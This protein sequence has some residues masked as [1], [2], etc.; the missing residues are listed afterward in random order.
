VGRA[1]GDP[2]QGQAELPNPLN[3]PPGCAFANRCP[4]AS[5]QCRKTVPVLEQIG[6]E[7]RVACYHPLPSA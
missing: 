2:E 6:P 7:Q 4:Y 3:P 5:D 1:L